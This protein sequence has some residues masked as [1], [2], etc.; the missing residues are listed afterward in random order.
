[1]QTGL[2]LAPLLPDLSK[3]LA[4]TN[5][6]IIS[7]EPGTGKTTL[8]PLYLLS[9]PWLKSQKI[10]ML[11][12]RRLAA[13]A[14][15]R[16]MSVLNGTVLG[17]TVGYRISLESCVT[18][19][20]RIEVL[21][22]GILTRMIRD[23]PELP[24]VGVVIFDEFHERNIHADLAL[25]LCLEV[26]EILRPDLKIIVMS[27]TLDLAGL[28]KLLPAAP[29]LTCS[30]PRFHVDVSYHPPPTQNRMAL[31]QL[32]FP[33]FIADQV[34]EAL[35]KEAGDVLVFLPGQG[36]ISR[37]QSELAG[38]EQD[39]RIHPLFGNLSNAEQLTALSP[40]ETGQRRI[41]L[42]TSLAE[43]SLTI[44]GIRIVIDS[45]LSR[46]NRFDPKTSMDR[47]VTERVSLASSIQRQG[48][49]GRLSD[50]VCWKLWAATEKLDPFLA[51]EIE[52]SDLTTLVLEAC[53][54]GARSPGDLHWLSPP[55][56]VLWN[57]A[58]EL[59]FFLGAIDE[60]KVITEHGKQLLRISIHPRLGHMVAS[61]ETEETRG[62][63]LACAALLTERDLF[64]QS[65]EADFRLRLDV[66]TGRKPSSGEEIHHSTLERVRERYR[67]WQ[68]I[69]A[70]PGLDRLPETLLEKAGEVLALAFPDR[71]GLR[72]ESSEKNQFHL[73]NGRDGVL[74]GAPQSMPMIVAP[75]VDAGATNAKIFL[76]APIEMDF[77]MRRFPTDLRTETVVSWLGLKPRLRKKILFH[78]LT[79]KQWDS[80]PEP[81]DRQALAEAFQERLLREGADFFPWSPEIYKWRER[82]QF[83]HKHLLVQRP[84][85][86]PW[87]DLSNSALLKTSHEW[88]S[89][90]FKIGTGPILL[91][92]DLLNALQ[93]LFTPQQLKALEKNVPETHLLPTGN[94]RRLEY[95]ELGPPVLS[96]RIQELFGETK[97]PLVCGIPIVIHLLSPAQ[98][99][100]QV[101]SDL[102]GFWKNSYPE[103]RKEMRGRYPKHYWPENPLEAEPTSR[104]KSK[105]PFPRK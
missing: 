19:T 55:S 98:R 96:V 94:R 51:P 63:S 84:D 74:S 49:A 105:N 103:I 38:I 93:S 25:A 60:K 57:Q 75:Q 64:V 29:I 92:E 61:S 22:E 21:T 34:K 9:S 52:R 41:I 48:R 31:G 88:I 100:L 5:Q 80:I 11:E 23:N 79:L 65:R 18:P 8:V 97:S 82:C 87:P 32:F 6:Y 62:L 81:S 44:P 10:L 13:Q 20:T 37:L 1:M 85:L 35:R 46:F 3:Q 101:T 77:I 30:V 91:P 7:A 66:L 86:A 68:K 42:A 104:P 4:C 26:Q 56:S 102:A 70:A 72:M 12:P 53:S 89:R 69:Y 54:W 58:M 67:T 59:L 27:A 28:Q 71:I 95:S 40:S 50:G 16:R 76:F 43:T 73:S 15:A 90:F 33:T 99:P 45:G 2:P 47:L 78:K 83:A 24:G 14:A 39:I 17:Q 36:E